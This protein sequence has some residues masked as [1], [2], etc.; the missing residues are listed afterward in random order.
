MSNDIEDEKNA[1]QP[2]GQTTPRHILLLGQAV[3][4]TRWVVLIAV[5]AVLLVSLSLFVLGAIEAVTAVWRAW[6]IMLQQGQPPDLSAYFLEIVGVMLEAVVFFLIGIG[7]FS[8]FISPLNLAVALGVETMNDLEE[9]V[10]GVVVSVLAVTFLEHFVRWEKPL[11]TLQFG[12][13]LSLTVIA[14]VLFQRYSH[15]A[16]ED[17][18]AHMPDTQARSRKE[19]FEESK[20]SHVIHADEVNGE[21]VRHRD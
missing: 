20:E 5:V 18:K 3:G 11:E 2:P 17:Q 21:S 7:L 12:G 9:R 16:K 8:L 13:A 14:L 19:M 10:I 6:A 15:R 4:H 1:T